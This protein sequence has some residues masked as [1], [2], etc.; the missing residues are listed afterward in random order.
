MKDVDNKIANIVLTHNPDVADLPIWNKYEGWILSGHTHGGQ[1]KPPFL[2]T[3]LLPVNNKKYTS[4]VIDLQDGRMMYINRALG[5]L[6][7]L[8]FNV[9]P[10]ITVFELQPV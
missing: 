4:G 6:W 5:H 8:R 7:P 3:P 9:R 2:P 10:E 1:C